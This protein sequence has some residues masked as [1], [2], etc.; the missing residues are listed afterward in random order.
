MKFFKLIII[1]ILF[2]SVCPAEIQAEELSVVGVVEKH[3]VYVGESFAFQI[4]VAGDE[5]PQNPDISQ[6]KEFHVVPRG[7]Q[8]NSSQS[9]TIINGQVNRISKRGYIFNYSLTPKREGKLIIPSITVVAGGRS[10]LTKPI[11]IFAS[12]PHETDDFKLRMRLSKSKCYVGEPTELSVIWYIGKDVEEFSFSLPHQED[13][14]FTVISPDIKQFSGQQNIVKIPVGQ[15]ALYAKKERGVLDGREY[16]TVQFNQTLIPNKTGQFKIPQATVSSKVL[17]G[18]SRGRSNDPFEGFFGRNR[19]GVYSTVITPSNEPNIKVLPLPKKGKPADFNGLVGSYSIFTQASPQK[20]NV[21]DPITLTIMV[22]G[23]KYLGN[24]T[25]PPLQSNQKLKRD[26]KIPDEMAPGEIKG[27]KKVFTQ[28]IRAQH[29]EVKSIP[30]LGL[31]F[32]NPKSK[33]YEAVHSEPIPIQVKQTK[34]VTV[35][36]AEGKDVIMS[37]K[38]N[39]RALKQ[40]IAQNVE[41]FSLLEDQEFDRAENLLPLSWLLLLLAPPGLFLFVIVSFVVAKRNQ[42][43]RA[44]LAQKAYKTFMGSLKKIESALEA[45]PSQSYIYLADAIREYLGNKLLMP[46]KTLTFQDVKSPLMQHGISSE[47]IDSLK[48]SM[49]GFEEHQYAGGSVSQ[50][51]I[52]SDLKKAREIITQIERAFS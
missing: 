31:P 22:T 21:G 17:Q 1:S 43:P 28:T 4:Q 6:I 23:P 12:K 20:V 48:K 42:D 37:N 13:S 33:H 9:V 44:L 30:A 16:L 38:K 18:Y 29:A 52:G 45:Q 34:V 47:T 7:G 24:V 26:F 27:R 32:F 46:S 14:R 25:L 2:F 19:R 5:S 49:V 50:A 10:L 39:I 11:V 36:D 3:N 41:D 8:Q 35:M 15:Q 51:E 40:G